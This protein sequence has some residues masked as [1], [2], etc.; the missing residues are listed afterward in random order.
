MTISSTRTGSEF[1]AGM[2]PAPEF[3]EAEITNGIVKAKL[4]LPDEKT[5]FYRGTRFDWSG[6][7]GSLEYAGHEFYPQWFQRTDPKVRDF[8]YDGSDIVAGSC[9]AITGP[10]EEFMATSGPLG[11]HEAK[12]GGTFV[13]IGVGALRKPDDAGYDRFRVY[14]IVDGGTWSI[15]ENFDQIEFKQELSD[16]ASGYGYVY[17][18]TVALAKGKPRMTLEHSLRNTGKNVICGSV[19]NH[20]FLYL[21]RRP[22]GPDFV[23]TFPFAVQA[24][25]PPDENLVAVRGN[26]IT[27]LKT[28]T[29]DECAQVVVGGYSA[30]PKDYDIRIENRKAGAGLRITGTRPLS[31]V[32]IWSIR[33][34]LSVE[35]FIDVNIEPGAVFSWKIRYDFYTLPK[36]VC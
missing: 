30:D 2:S 25:Q 4:Y 1:T 33:A 24:M 9:T 32:Y 5:G 26:Q 3:P 22:P 21:D 17:C 27:Y 12:A 14:D 18:K 23:I 15:R 13:K 19:Y 16:L 11:Y 31:H 28:L 20:N 8:I 7:V 29:G 36:G 6:I 35:P 34:P 10:S